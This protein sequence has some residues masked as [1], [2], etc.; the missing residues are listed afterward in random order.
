MKT[1]LIMASMLLMAAAANAQNNDPTIM[2]VNGQPVPRSE[3]EYSYNKNNSEG[4]IDKKSVDEYVDLFVNYKLKVQAAK[5]ARLDTLTSFKDEFAMYRD[6]QIK[7]SFVTDEGMLREAQKVYNDT[8]ESI[9][10]RGLI[11]PAHIL[12]HVEQQAPAEEMQ[13]AKVRIDSIY[14]ALKNGADFADLAKRLSQDPGSAVNGG[15]LPWIGPGQT[16]KEFEDQA[17]AL[18]KGEM[19][20]PF[21]SPYG[22]HI[23]LMKDRKQLEPFDS[24]KNDIFAF[25]ERRGGREH[26]ADQAIKEMAQEQGISTAQL[27]EKRAAEMSAT[28]MDLK[29]L[30]QEYHDGLLLY[31]ISNQTVWDKA[32]KDELGLANYFQKNKKKYGWDEPRYKGI[33]YHVKDKADVKAVKKSVK[34]LPFSQWADKLRSTFNNDS[35]IRIRVEKGIFKKGDNAVIDKMVFKKDTT[36][37][38]LKDYPIDAVYGKLL[39]KGPE[40]Y[41]DVRALV[42][43]DYQEELEKAWVEDLRKRYSVVV[44]KDVLQTVNKH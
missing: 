35:I 29:Y 17:Y 14:T 1:R 12:M 5:D 10:P 21:Q 25:L 27:L 30:I 43:A 41:Q 18:Q 42:V 40:E 38:T 9:G 37:T 2:T 34:G 13:K 11:M 24:L 32:A 28:D 26:V 3:F 31:E 33:A 16:V 4:V 23:I 15:A 8:K 36:V 19:S 6:Q 22:Y 7:P 20:Q 39:K 44:N